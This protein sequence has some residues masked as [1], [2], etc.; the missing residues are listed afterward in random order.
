MKRNIRKN[1]LIYQAKSFYN[2][3][4]NLERIHHESGDLLFFV[5]MVVNA[6][7]SVEIAFKAILVCEDI[8]YENE[9]NLFILYSLLPDKAKVLVQKWVEKKTPEYDLESFLSELVLVSDSFRQWR[10][11]FEGGAPP[12]L[13][14]RFLMCLANAAIG[15]MF[16]MGYNVD[17]VE[18]KEEISAEE[19]ERIN[20][21]FEENRSD[22]LEMNKRHIARK[23]EQDRKS[24]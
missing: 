17:L 22:A 6:A 24:K 18:M 14:M 2:A 13:E 3:A 23:I 9:H 4:I 7:F 11:S 15:T 19:I 5:P 8:S 1:A 12:A 20:Q 16:E 10:Y 21:M